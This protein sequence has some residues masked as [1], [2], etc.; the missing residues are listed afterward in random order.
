MKV[1]KRVLITIV[2]MG[3][4]IVA[5]YGVDKGISLYNDKVFEEE[6]EQ[7][8]IEVTKETETRKEEIKEISQLST[9]EIKEYIDQNA[10]VDDERIGNIDEDPWN[11]ASDNS[12]PAEVDNEDDN[13]AD[14]VPD[15]EDENEADNEG[16]D[17]TDKDWEAGSVKDNVDRV[18]QLGMEAVANM[19][20][21][22]NNSVDEADTVS[23]NS[24]SGNSVS[25]NSVS[26]NSV[27]GN[28]VSGNS[29]SG[30]SVSG[31]TVSGNSLGGSLAENK[32]YLV[33]RQKFRT[34][35]EETQLWMSAD[36]EVIK[37][38]TEDFSSLK[39]ACLGDS[40]T[41]ATN[42]A[43]V[44]SADEYRAYSYPARL[45]ELLG[46]QVSNYGIGGSSYGR[47]W[48]KAFCERYQDIPEDTD[49]III[50][51]GA[52]DG[53]CLHEDMVGSMDNREQRTLYGDLD[54]LMRGLKENY[55]DAEVIFMTPMPN[56]L[57]DVL[58][59]DRPE[60]LS[61]TVIV[62]AVTELAAEYGYSVIDLY[63]SNFFDS[64]D[65]DIVST[66]IPD[67]VHPNEEGY[68]IFAKH[69]AAEIMRIHENENVLN[70]ESEDE[71]SDE[72]ADESKDEDEEDSKDDDE[73][74]AVIEDPK[75]ED[76][77]GNDEETENESDDEGEKP[78]SESKKVIY[79]R[80]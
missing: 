10:Y 29:V 5:A 61:Q 68:E 46:A 55:P 57:H 64:H 9:E 6:R 30:N 74:D 16:E 25:G 63:N 56:L 51:G 20:S 42:L 36:E 70:D 14:N 52:N 60:L 73:D 41:D 44:Y 21:V 71:L 1:I 78:A 66:Y 13:E 53:F 24:V 17:E 19:N 23:G 2:A 72:D 38:N 31:N 32:I 22:S 15:N 40:I 37:N 8:Y 43:D 45:G 48:D 69:V 47:Y 18:A 35:S 67:S 26:G 58:R 12:E 7:R 49:M 11:L 28:S 39:I 77:A 76:K 34:S 65:A 54:E 59:K 27:S 4:I 50:M 80:E 79:A 62:D 3:A 75:S 33:D